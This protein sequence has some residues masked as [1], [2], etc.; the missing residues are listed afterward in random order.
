[1][2]IASIDIGTN[3]VL[4]LIAEVDT[5]TGSIIPLLND[6]RL[7]RIGKGLKQGMP[8]S[9]DKVETLINILADFKIKAEKYKCDKIIATAT[10][11]LRIAS[12]SEII[13]SIVKEKTGI[14][15]EVIHGDEEAFF[16]YLGASGG[17]INSK[18]TIVIDIGGGSTEIVI[19]FEDNIKYKRS[20]HIGAVAAAE[21]FLK[22]APPLNSEME[23]FNNNLELIFDDLKKENFDF[24]QAIAIAGTPTTLAAIKMNLSKFD[25]ELIEGSTI[26]FSELSVLTDKLKLLTPE[27]IL[28]DFKEVVKGR[29]DVLLS[30]SCILLYLCGILRIDEVIVSTRGIRYGAIVNFIKN[31]F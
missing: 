26:N 6:Y 19:G 10:N 16:S 29:E 4:L 22:H 8:V 28:S 12:N 20:F 30:G 23:N 15:I 21:A 5:V 14:D 17:L 24:D 2:I 11:A 25:E 3:T 27:Q 31:K 13:I 1:M 9:S 18:R 7:P